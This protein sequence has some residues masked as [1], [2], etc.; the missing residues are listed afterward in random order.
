ML[1]W[2]LLV[3]YVLSVVA[4]GK[5]AVINLIAL[6]LWG[7]MPLRPP[8]QSFL[9]AGGRLLRGSGTAVPKKR[10]VKKERLCFIKTRSAGHAMVFLSKPEDFEPVL[11]VSNLQGLPLKV[12]IGGAAK[13]YASV[14]LATGAERDFFV[15]FIT[16]LVPEE[17]NRLLEMCRLVRI[18]FVLPAAQPLSY[19]FSGMFL[20][21]DNYGGLPALRISYPERRQY[22]RVEPAFEKP[23]PVS[24][25]RAQTCFTGHVCNISEGGLNFYSRQDAA[26]LPIGAA[27]Q[28]MLHLPGG[29]AIEPELAVRWLQKVMPARTVFGVVYA[30]CCG[31]GFV[32]LD[33]LMRS[34]IIGY[35]DQREQEEFRKLLHHEAEWQIL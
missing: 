6:H 9:L 17:G 7:V 21:A 14:V 15:L 26:K 5:A 24:A 1:L 16:P 31:G 34:A 2:V 20:G 27:L 19:S 25:Q 33:N 4:T 3:T 30:C 13:G 23:L 22:C 10:L 12:R 18:E 11:A 32:R 28:I 29:K 35:I 8:G